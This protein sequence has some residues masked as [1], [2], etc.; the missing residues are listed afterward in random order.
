[1][2]ILKLA[3]TMCT[4]SSR[5]SINY[6]ANWIDEYMFLKYYISKKWNWFPKMNPTHRFI[7][8]SSINNPRDYVQSS[9][10]LRSVPWCDHVGRIS[11]RH[12]QWLK[13]IYYT[14][15]FDV[16]P[17][18][19]DPFDA[20]SNCSIDFKNIHNSWSLETLIIHKLA[21]LPLQKLRLPE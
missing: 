18:N 11:Q 20:F 19:F 14:A 15:A 3:I 13:L 7:S 16:G 12:V 10:I 2:E 17:V 6:R 5:V 8:T 9:T 4:K 1:L 21:Q